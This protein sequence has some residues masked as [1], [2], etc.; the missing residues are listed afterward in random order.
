MAGEYNVKG[1]INAVLQH[2][3]QIPGGVWAA[4]MCTRDLES[5]YTRGPTSHLQH[6]T[7]RLIADLYEI[8][9]IVGIAESHLNNL[10]NT[11]GWAVDYDEE[12]DVY[13]VRGP[14][15]EDWE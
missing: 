14:C 8:K 12:R 15:S 13:E 5:E 2:I 6:L 3:A 11:L 10:V 7:E 1:E 9:R 4:A